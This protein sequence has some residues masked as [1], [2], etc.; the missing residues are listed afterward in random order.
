MIT[1]NS[2]KTRPLHYAI[3]PVEM[4]EVGYVSLKMTFVFAFIVLILSSCSLQKLNTS[5]ESSV[6][7]ISDTK[8]SAAIKPLISAADAHIKNREWSKSITILE[9]ALRINKRQAETWARM[10][11]AYKGKNEFEQAIQMAKRSNSYA[12]QNTD[13]K[14]YNWQLIS[15]A[16]LKLNKL[17]KSQ[18]AAIKSQQLQGKN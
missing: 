6:L 17:D 16:Y 5:S 2:K 10:A 9:R 14:A 7:A 12:S 8:L 15:D 4:T 3:A 1:L 18:A 11:L 13:L